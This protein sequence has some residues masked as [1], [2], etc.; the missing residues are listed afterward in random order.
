MRFRKSALILALVVIL[1]N[2]ATPQVFAQSQP[3][4]PQTPPQQCFKQDE[5]ATGK[6]KNSFAVASQEC[7][8]FVPYTYNCISSP[9]PVKLNTPLAGLTEI[10]GLQNYIVIIYKFLIG[11]AGILA[12]IMIVIAGFEWLT[13]AGDSGK[14]KHSREKIMNALIGLVLALGSYTILYT[15]NPAL[16]SLQMAPIKLIRQE[17]MPAKSERCTIGLS[18]LTAT[19]NGPADRAACALQCGGADKIIAYQVENG[20]GCCSCKNPCAALAARDPYS[21][22]SREAAQPAAD[23]LA[24]ESGYQYN[25]QRYYIEVPRPS[26][27]S[28]ASRCGAAGYLNHAVLDPCTWAQTASATPADAAKKEQQR[29]ACLADA[30]KVNVCCQCTGDDRVHRYDRGPGDA[31]RCQAL[32]NDPNPTDCMAYSG[33]DG[34]CTYGDRKCTW[35]PTTC[36]AS[37]PCPNPTSQQCIDNKCITTSTPNGAETNCAAAGVACGSDNNSIECCSGNSCI[38]R[39]LSSNYCRPDLEATKIPR[40]GLCDKDSDCSSACNDS[41]EGMRL[42]GRSMS[43]GSTPC[44]ADR[45]CTTACNKKR[46]K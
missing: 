19:A 18:E 20:A 3:A 39:V 34:M 38:T 11:S 30:T 23:P 44:N 17:E 16:L 28:C 42:D 40:G 29:A 8:S 21:D 32:S 26:G 2:S 43:C 36:S 31:A 14:I 45:Q 4:T 22:R 5:C 12:G 24:L 35:K 33:A 6:Y 15:I 41:N 10:T 27:T 1:F 7:K 46:C 9:P 37:L 13:A 25:G